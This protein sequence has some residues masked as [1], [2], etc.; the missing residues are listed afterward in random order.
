MF[1][2]TSVVNLALPRIGQDLPSTLFGTLEAQSYVAYGYFVTLS[3]LLILA[4]GLTDYH[5]RRKMFSLGLI[6]FGAT[7]LLCGLAPSIEF[8]IVARVLQGAAGAFVV[9]GSLVDHHGELPRRGARAGVRHLGRRI[10]GHHDPRAVRGRRAG[11]LDLVAAAFLVNLPLLVVA[12]IATVKYVPESRDPDATGH[13]DWL[14]SIVIVLAVGGLAFGTIRGQQRG[15]DRTVGDREPG[16]SGPIAAI[17]FP[18]MMLHRRDPLVPPRLF[19]SRNFTVTN[20]STLVIYGALYVSFTFEGIFLIGVLGYNEQAAGIAGIPSSILLVL[21][22]TRFGQAGGTPRTAALHDGG[23][24]DH[25]V[26]SAVVRADPRRPARRG[27]WAGR[28]GVDPAAR[29][30]LRRSS[31]RRCWCSVRGSRSWWRRSRRR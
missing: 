27:S 12:Y 18:F 14:G 9:P 19:R 25:G 11:Q 4:G 13:F 21:F 16:R 8:L 10:G 31:C 20:L 15:L 23:P 30:L 17:A 1:L 24:G 5:G 26:G 2:D 3:S 22:S 6:G 29:R 7:S 28:V